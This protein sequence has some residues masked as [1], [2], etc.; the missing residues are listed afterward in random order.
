MMKLAEKSARSVLLILLAVLSLSS[1][2]KASTGDSEALG[3]SFGPFFQKS[4]YEKALSELITPALVDRDGFSDAPAEIEVK[5]DGATDKTSYKIKLR[6]DIFFSDGTKMTA[7]DIIFTLYVLSDPSYTGRSPL[8]TVDIDGFSEYRLGMSENELEEL[9][10]IFDE[11]IGGVFDEGE[12]SKEEI[13]EVNS[14][15]DKA[16]AQAV[17]DI[18]EAVAIN[19]GTDALV[20]EHFTGTAQNLSHEGFSIAYAMIAR[21]FARFDNGI[22]ISSDNISY[23]IE[24]GEFPDISDFISCTKNVCNNNLLLFSEAQT[25]GICENPYERAKFDFAV[26]CS[27]KKSVQTENR[28]RIEGIKKL[29]SNEVEIVTNGYDERAI[30]IIGGLSVAPLHYYGDKGS[31]DY[32]GGRFGFEKGELGKIISKCG[33]PLGWGAYCLDYCED[34][35]IH[36]TASDSFYKGISEPRNLSFKKLD[37]TIIPCL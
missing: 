22:L 8:C 16:W 5:Y 15:S 21:G 31:Y 35:V 32:E 29:G 2:A 18:V 13:N 34:G 11:V 7:D 36:L 4:V 20:S 26:S 14:A 37:D 28:N 12:Y 24:G 30:E 1:C 19:C 3:K 10:K 23:D 9:G 6:D 27:E 17:R 33:T 25:K